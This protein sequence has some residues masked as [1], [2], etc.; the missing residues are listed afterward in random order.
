MTTPNDDK[1]A[2]EV[3]KALFDHDYSAE[4]SDGLRDAAW[5]HRRIAYTSR[6]SAAI[7]VV[8]AATEAE[9]ARLRKALAS[10]IKIAGEARREWDAA[11]GG[12]RA[13]KILIALA[14]GAKGYRA[15][16][17]AIHAALSAPDGGVSEREDKTRAG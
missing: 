17:D 11:P 6:A 10:A 13:G 7:A 16:I 2:L 3:A 1:L 14:G 4:P 15:D 12:M 8:K 9:N 5:K